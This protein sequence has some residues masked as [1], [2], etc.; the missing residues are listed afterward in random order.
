MVQLHGEVNARLPSLCLQQRRSIWLSQK[1]Q[2]S[3][4]GCNNSSRNLVKVQEKRQQSSVPTI[5]VRSLSQRIQLVTLSPNTPTFVTTSLGMRLWI[6][7]FGCSIF[8]QRK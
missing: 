1:P 6:R 8:P 4:N 2:K 7:S 3:S 5:R